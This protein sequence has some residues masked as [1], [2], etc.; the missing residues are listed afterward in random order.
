MAVVTPF[1]LFKRR[2]FVERH[3]RLIAR[4]GADTGERYLNRQM[5]IQ[6]DVLERRGVERQLIEKEIQVLS[7]AIIAALWKAVLTPS[8]RG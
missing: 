7:S 8:G 1:P 2:P 6:V 5:Q 3:A 4:L